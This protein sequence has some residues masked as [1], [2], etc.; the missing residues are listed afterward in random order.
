MDLLLRRWSRAKIDEGEVGLLA[1][2]AGIGKS[3][4]VET[5]RQLIAETPHTT[6]HYQCSPHHADSPLYPVIAQIEIGAGIALDDSPAVRLEKLEALVKR[7]TDRWDEVIPLLAALL[8][9]PT[10]DRDPLPD[11]DPQRRRERTLAAL[12]E[13]LQAQAHCS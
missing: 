9:I 11:P 8:S 1:R 4:V 7:S 3:R 13:Q 6:L 10:A 5:F 12:I 2:E